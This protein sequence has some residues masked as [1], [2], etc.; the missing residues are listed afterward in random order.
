[1]LNEII[2]CKMCRIGCSLS[3]N[4][5][6]IIYAINMKKTKSIRFIIMITYQPPPYENTQIEILAKSR[7]IDV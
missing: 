5:A 4:V 6:S 3:Q 7:R 1:M 2:N